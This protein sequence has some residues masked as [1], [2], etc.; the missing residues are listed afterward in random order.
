[1]KFLASVILLASGVICSFATIEERI[2]DLE[3]VVQ[4]QFAE[5]EQMRDRLKELE[6]EVAEL[7][8]EESESYLDD[9]RLTEKRDIPLNGL[10]GH[11]L[12]RLFPFSFFTYYRSHMRL[13]KPNFASF[14]QIMYKLGTW[15]GVFIS[16]CFTT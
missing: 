4:G 13:R 3:T 5:N 11:L 9:Q 10:P 8:E 7:V 16:F 14:H 2:S 1:M 12:T 15:K 6:Q